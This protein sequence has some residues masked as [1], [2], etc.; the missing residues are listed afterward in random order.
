[1]VPRSVFMTKPYNPDEVCK[2]LT[3]LTE[4]AH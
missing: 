2:L 4:T 3:R 1:L